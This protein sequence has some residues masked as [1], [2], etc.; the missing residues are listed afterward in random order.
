M[1]PEQA[2]FLLQ[3]TL[4]NLENEFRTTKKILNAVPA[5]Q[6]AYKPAADCKSALD[7][8]WHIASSEIYFLSSVAQGEFAPPSGSRPESVQTPADVAAFYANAVPPIHE[9]LKALTP[10]QAAKVLNFRGVFVM[11]AVAFLPF[12]N[13]HTAHHRGQLSVYLRP[14]GAKVPAIYGGSHDEPMHLPPPTA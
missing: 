6:G 1:Q 9:A 4:P 2:H 5:D 13:L 11:P 3:A 8:A 7:L 10:E 12:M 14:M